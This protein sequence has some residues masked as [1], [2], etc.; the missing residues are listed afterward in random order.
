MFDNL[1]IEMGPAAA[2][3]A[4]VLLLML[5]AALIAGQTCALLRPRDRAPGEPR[6]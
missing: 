1:F 3:L 2:A 6:S 4:L 5:P